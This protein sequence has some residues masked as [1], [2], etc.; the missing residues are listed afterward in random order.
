MGE[1]E[2]R[3]AADENRLRAARRR[4]K[5]LLYRGILP[6]PFFSAYH[7][8]SRKSTKKQPFYRCARHFFKFSLRIGRIFSLRRQHTISGKHQAH[9]ERSKYDGTKE[10][11]T[12]KARPSDR[13]C[14]VHCAYELRC[15]GSPGQLDRT[16]HRRMDRPRSGCG[17]FVRQTGP[18]GIPAAFSSAGK[19]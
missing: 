12:K 6:I 19:R 1:R 2:K 13:A 3:R 9:P 8:V 18:P 5:T 11:G 16:S 14:A 17:R 10:K 15:D 4:G 7:K